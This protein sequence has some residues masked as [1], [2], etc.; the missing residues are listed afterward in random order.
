MLA[1]ISPASSTGIFEGL[2]CSTMAN[3]D[4]VSIV[5]LQGGVLSED[6]EEDSETT[7]GICGTGESDGDGTGEYIVAIL[8]TFKGRTTHLNINQ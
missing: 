5:C 1:V 4:W 7:T 3:F 6:K 2:S 8:L